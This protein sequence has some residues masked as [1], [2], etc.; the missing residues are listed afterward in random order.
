MTMCA[1][2]ARYRS[3]MPPRKALVNAL[4]GLDNLVDILPESL[5]E[6]AE[7]RLDALSPLA[8]GESPAAEPPVDEQVQDPPT[9]SATDSVDEAAGIETGETQ[10]PTSLTPLHDV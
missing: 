4:G 7:E 1:A 3:S 9:D 2:H 10:L 5:I 8:L 6:D